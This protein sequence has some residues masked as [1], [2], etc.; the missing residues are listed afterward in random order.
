MFSFPHIKNWQQ[1]IKVKDEETRLVFYFCLYFLFKKLDALPGLFFFFK[2]TDWNDDIFSGIFIFVWYTLTTPPPLPPMSLY[3]RLS[4][5]SGISVKLLW[6]V[7][8]SFSLTC[9]SSIYSPFSISSLS[10]CCHAV[11]N[12]LDAQPNRILLVTVHHMLYPITVD[13]LFQVF[14]PHGTVEKI[15]TFQKSAGQIFRFLPSLL[16]FPVNFFISGH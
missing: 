14:S 13:V 9:T 16:S 4:H 7:F 2:K 8:S 12:S 11:G 3:A 15:V 1:W 6:P 5:F 10:L